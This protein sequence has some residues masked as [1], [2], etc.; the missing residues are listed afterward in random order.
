[1]YVTLIDIDMNQVQPMCF[2][3]TPSSNRKNM[4]EHPQ[5]K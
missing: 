1:M 2:P 4:F 5:H 3:E